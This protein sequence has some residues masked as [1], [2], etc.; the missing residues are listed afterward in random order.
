MMSKDIIASD[1]HMC[2]HNEF[3]VTIDSG[4]IGGEDKTRLYDLSE[5]STKDF[6]SIKKRPSLECIIISEKGLA[7]FLGEELPER[8]VESYKGISNF[9]N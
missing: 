5:L 3:L 7:R 2:E 8:S 6:R 9:S 4:T 1:D